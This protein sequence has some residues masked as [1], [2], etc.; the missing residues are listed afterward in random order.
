VPPWSSLLRAASSAFDLPSSSA[1][2]FL[3]NSWIFEV[4]AL[5]SD[6]FEAMYWRSM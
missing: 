4:A 2:F 1:V 3:V 5:P 6:E